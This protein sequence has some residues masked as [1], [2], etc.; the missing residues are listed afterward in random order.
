MA[1]LVGGG[2]NAIR[3]GEISCAHRGVLFLD[4]LGEFRAEVLDA[5]RQPVEDGVMYV[6]RVRS[7]AVLPA[8]FI[9]VAAMNPC[10]CGQ[11]RGPG[12]CRC[13][14]R[15]RARWV[16]RL[17]GPLLD[18]FDLRVRVERPE[19][20]ELLSR[21][22]PPG[23]GQ[24]GDPGCPGTA[25]VSDR[26]RR[27]RALSAE[28]GVG[29]NAAIPRARLDELAPLLPEARRALEAKLH[30]GLL[31]ARGLHRVRR[32]ARTIADLDGRAGPLRA[33]DVHA[34]AALR[35]DPFGGGTPPW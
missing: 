15:A 1:A 7:S 3:P 25:Q 14:E 33:A 17:S 4:E 12:S 24:G 32:V 28:R 26:V 31:S 23:S 34:A 8:R 35:A 21:T 30:Q 22:S 18:R 16:A 9:L 13:S 10:P 2:S 29:V 20:A 11:D 27:A 19:P 5:L 6:S